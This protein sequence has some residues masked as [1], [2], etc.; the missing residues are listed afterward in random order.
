[1]QK[2]RYIDRDGAGNIVFA[3]NDL[4]AWRAYCNRAI[5]IVRNK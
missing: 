1:M 4:A 3:T 5:S 2:F